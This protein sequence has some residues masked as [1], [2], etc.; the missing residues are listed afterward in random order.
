MN[1]SQRSIDYENTMLVTLMIAGSGLATIGL[2][3]GYYA[4]AAAIAL[5]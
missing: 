1:Y 4:V 5:L 3:G 2:I